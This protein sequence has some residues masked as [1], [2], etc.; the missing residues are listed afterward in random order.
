MRTWFELYEYYTVLKCHLKITITNPSSRNNAIILVGH[1]WNAYTDSQTAIG[2]VTPQSNIADMLSYK[3]IT[4]HTIN[5]NVSRDSSTNTQII[6]LTWRPGIVKRNIVNDGDVKTW[7]KTNNAGSPQAPTIIEEL[8]LYFYT[9]PLYTANGSPYTWG[10]ANIQIEA[11]YVVQFKDLKRQAR[12]PNV[13][14][15][16]QTAVINFT[17]TRTDAGNPMATWNT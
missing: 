10:C 11:K 17:N 8:R 1:D 15:N 12:Y 14:D 16:Q 6:D 4:W 13:F 2:N 3:N 5:S 7:S 9:H